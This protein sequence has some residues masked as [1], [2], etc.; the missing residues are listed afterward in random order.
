MIDISNKN[1]V[2]FLGLYLAKKLN[3]STHIQHITKKVSKTVG[4]LSK[5]RYYV[6]NSALLSLY[7]ALIYP[8]LTY[9]ICAWD[10][11]TANCLKPIITQQKWAT[12][13][14]TNYFQTTLSP[15]V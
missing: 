15:L 8:Y 5:I 1:D 7:Y 6:P 9:G 4:T 2:K 3:F 11:T 10:S 12:R 13:T 14:I